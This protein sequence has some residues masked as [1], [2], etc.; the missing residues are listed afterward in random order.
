MKVPLTAAL[1]AAFFTFA[2]A[3]RADEQA[4]NMGPLTPLSLIHI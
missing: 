4:T 1:L 2:I 3:A